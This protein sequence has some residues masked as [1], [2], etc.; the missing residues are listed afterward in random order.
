MKLFRRLITNSSK[1]FSLG[2][3]ACYVNLKLS[4]F[5]PHL[6][7]YS[8]LIQAEGPRFGVTDDV[9]GRQNDAH[10]HQA[11]SEGLLRGDFSILA[12]MR[13]FLQL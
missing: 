2:W 10:W 4:Y 7:L 5:S 9:Q 3:P 6:M 1:H 11:L 8:S 12:K 13:G